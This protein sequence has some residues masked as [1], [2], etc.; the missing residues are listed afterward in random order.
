MADSNQL[1]TKIEHSLSLVEKR[2]L[3]FF[4]STSSDHSPYL[5]RP[6]RM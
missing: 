4:R 2:A 5:S 1:Q 6:S 3:N